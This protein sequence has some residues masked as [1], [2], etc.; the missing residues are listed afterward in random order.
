MSS[1]TVRLRTR[2]MVNRL[3]VLWSLMMI[4]QQTQKLKVMETAHLSA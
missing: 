2:D 4:W 1:M 3:L